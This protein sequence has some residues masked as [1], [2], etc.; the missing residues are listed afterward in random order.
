[1]ISVPTCLT[2]WSKKLMLQYVSQIAVC[3]CVEAIEEIAV[4]AADSLSICHSITHRQKLS[5]QI[6][7]TVFAWHV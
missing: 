6:L 7:L 4:L 3:V 1:M 5:V 2:S